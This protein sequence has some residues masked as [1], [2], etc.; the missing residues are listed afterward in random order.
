MDSFKVEAIK[1]LIRPFSKRPSARTESEISIITKTISNIKFFSSMNE[2]KNLQSLLNEVAKVLSLE[3][4]EPGEC[5][6]NYG[7]VGNKFY[8][9]LYGK[10]GVLIPDISKNHGSPFEIRASISRRSFYQETEIKQMAKKEK[11]NI[12]ALKVLMTGGIQFNR[13]ESLKLDSNLMTRMGVVEEMKEVAQLKQGDSFGELALI[14]DKP[15]AATVEAKEISVLAVLSKQ[16]FKKALAQE[17]EK[18][19]KE[20][21]NFLYKL[22]VFKGYTNQS[23]QK[24]SYYFQELKFKK[25]Q[26]V[27][28]ENSP[29]DHLYFVYEGEFKLFQTKDHSIRKII[30]YPGGFLSDLRPYITIDKARD[31]RQNFQLQ[32]TIKGK[33]ETIGYE[34]YVKDLQTRVQSCICVSSSAIAYSIKSEVTF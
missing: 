5:I 32:F 16:D 21:V 6:V 25:G 1:Q 15:R 3:I 12:E 30:D 7:E 28:R 23:V 17:T 31:T 2:G 18:A 29:A 22:P 4:Y 26:Y 19:L 10:L 13:Q 9:V 34:E 8:I 33:N 14:S 27:Y 11:S 24:L 20:K